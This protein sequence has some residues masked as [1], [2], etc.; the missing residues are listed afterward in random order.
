TVLWSTKIW[1]GRATL[2]SP[3]APKYTSSTEGVLVRQVRTTSDAWATSAGLLAGR[4]PA[5]ASSST[6]ARLRLWPGGG[7]P[8]ARSLRLIRLPILPRP[9]NPTFIETSGDE[10]HHRN[11]ENAETC[12]E[13][14]WLT[15]CS[16]LSTFSRFD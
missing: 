9:T 14:I 5:M 13:P 2:I 1:P 6:T 7:N 3:F 10:V 15:C 4:A 8:A 12:G 11:T 16:W